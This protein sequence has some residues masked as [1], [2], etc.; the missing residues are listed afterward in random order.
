[1]LDFEF[2]Q[3]VHAVLSAPIEFRVAFLASKPLD[4]DDS[5]ALDARF[6]EGFVDLVEL[7]RFDDRGDQFHVGFLLLEWQ[8]SKSNIHANCCQLPVLVVRVA[9]AATPTGRH[10][11][12]GRSAH[13]NGAAWG[14]RYGAGASQQA[15]PHSGEDR[16]RAE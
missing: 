5:Q 10:A 2:G 3:K 7:E 4:L 6:D 12:P 15:T 11:P 8:V 9:A 1:H 14:E 16:W 13:R